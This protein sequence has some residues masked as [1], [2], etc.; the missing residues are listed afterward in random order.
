MPFSFADSPQ[1]M[2]FPSPPD[3]SRGMQRIVAFVSSLIFAS[4]FALPHQYE[5]ANPVSTAVLNSA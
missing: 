5:R 1:K 2:H 3:C 4:Q